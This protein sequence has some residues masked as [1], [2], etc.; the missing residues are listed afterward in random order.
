MTESCGTCR[1]W[2]AQNKQNAPV[3]IG[4]C[5]RFPPQRTDEQGVM[6]PDMWATEWCGEY[7]HGQTIP[8]IESPTGIAS[9]GFH[10]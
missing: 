5:R 2:Q 3:P 7:R 6:F 1:Y 8:N 9:D 10:L 4:W